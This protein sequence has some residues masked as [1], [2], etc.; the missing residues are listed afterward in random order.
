MDGAIEASVDLLL[1]VVRRRLD[2]A[3]AQ[4]E[5]GIVD[6]DIEAAEIL[7]QLVDHGFDGVE[8]CDVGRISLRLAAL[9]G[10]FGDQ[11]FGIVGRAAVIDRDGSAFGGKS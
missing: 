7:H 5:P 4:G 9:A 11:R 1:P 10:D 6:Q 3:L 8:I 2:K